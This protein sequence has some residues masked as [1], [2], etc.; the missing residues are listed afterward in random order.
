MPG[1]R[2]YVRAGTLLAAVALVFQPE[3][4]SWT[5][6]RLVADL[7][8][9][10][11]S[12]PSP[13]LAT[14]VGSPV[15]SGASSFDQATFNITVGGNRIGGSSDHFH[16]VYQPISG[17]VEVTARVDS[18]SHT[19]TNSAAGVMIRD[20][21]NSNAAHGSALV[22]A[23]AGTYFLRR[24][25]TGERSVRT[26]LTGAAPPRWV[27]AVRVG[28]NITAYS[29]LD[30]TNWATLGSATVPL[31]TTAYVGIATSSDRS[32]AAT[33]AAVSQ[34]S[35][36]PLSL[37]APQKGQDIGQPSINGSA[38]YREG[39]YTISAGGAN[40]GG[41]SD[42]FHFVHQPVQGDIDV[43]VRIASLDSSTTSS[44]KAGLM[45]RE[46]LT[47][48]SR[49]AFALITAGQG[50]AF[51]RR[52]DSG[53]ST[54]HTSGGSGAAPGWIRLV[55][56]GSRFEAFRSSDGQTWTSIGSDTVPMAESVYVGLAVTSR[57]T[58]QATVAVADTLTSGQPSPDPNR[59]PTVTLTAPA[60]GAVFPA[61][62]NIT[63]SASA[64]DPENG[65]D[66][67]EF[68]AGTTFLGAATTAPYSVTWPSVPPGTYSLLA[69]AYD[70]AGAN[71]SS[72]P[73]SITVGSAPSTQTNVV[74]QASSDHATMVSSYRL[75]VFAGGSDP[76]TSTPVASSDLGKPASDANGDITV[77]RSAFFNGLP[78]GS[79]LVTVSAVGSGG[80][81][82]SAPV[83]FTR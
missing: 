69:V 28:S 5:N 68:Y 49:H 3:S 44:A 35:V 34:V 22:S 21:L 73:S 72:A 70:T 66:R 67:V 51:D 82:R 77:D 80:E 45:I 58:S 8:A 38:I 41:T 20:S 31:G 71:A 42:Q 13:W 78:P 81:S 59:P 15:P 36:V 11:A 64:A 61:S 27:R 75:D 76:A 57:S 33:A 47:G 53:G 74:F 65:L 10:T 56:T 23:G 12:L 7:A 63:L 25:R 6:I 2:T 19:D 83:S 9:Q 62:A 46:S 30:G 60:N 40:I 43:A 17:N 55:R 37:P 50:Y 54:E 26:T 4:V 18:V 14:D 16:F 32:N 1:V 29:S 48:S 52:I 39:T 24:V 79:F